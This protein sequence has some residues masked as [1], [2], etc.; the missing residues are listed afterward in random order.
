ME[1]YDKLP[2]LDSSAKYAG[3]ALPEIEQD[4]FISFLAPVIS[5]NPNGWGPCQLP[6]KYKDLPYRP[7]QKT[8]RM[9]KAADWNYN[10][11]QKHRYG[12]HDSRDAAT[13]LEDGYNLVN[14][15]KVQKQGR[16]RWGVS[17][18]SSYP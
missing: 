15:T 9:M 7:F 10:E 4:G 3:D 11:Y 1:S 2:A 8:T 16:R 13:G 18:D 5:D 12:D 6:E 17:C 14:T